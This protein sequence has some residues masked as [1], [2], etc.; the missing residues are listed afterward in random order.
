VAPGRELGGEDGFGSQPVPR[1]SWGRSVYV[2]FDSGAALSPLEN[3]PPREGHDPHDDT[4]QI[5]AAQ[6]LKD[7][8][9]RP[10]GFVT[11]VCAG[12]PCTGPQF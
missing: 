5:P 6:A 11:D 2:L 7:T 3:L 9:S 12:G 10:Q 4:P 8:F 1:D